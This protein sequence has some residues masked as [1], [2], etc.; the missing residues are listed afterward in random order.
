MLLLYYSLYSNA[1]IT[2]LK[3]PKKAKFT[4]VINNKVVNAYLQ[5]VLTSQ[6][7]VCGDQLS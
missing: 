6:E 4:I 7:S 5:I 3:Y 2:E 1:Y